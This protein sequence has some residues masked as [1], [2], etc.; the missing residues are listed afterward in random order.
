MFFRLTFLLSVFLLSTQIGNAQLISTLPNCDNTSCFQRPSN[1][2]VAGDGSFVVVLDT[3]FTDSNP[4]VYLRKL[5]FS[6]A[7]FADEKRI[8]L[9]IGGSGNPNFQIS[10]S[11]DNKKLLV[12]RGSSDLAPPAIRVVDIESGLETPINTVSSVNLFPPSFADLAGQ[13]I[14]LSGTAQQNPELLTI[15]SGNGQVIKKTKI[16][17]IADTISPDPQFNKFV[18]T[19]V[20][21]LTKSVSIVDP[22]LN[23]LNTISIDPNLD[24]GGFQQVIRFSNDGQ[25]A[26][27][28]SLGGNHSFH[29]LDLSLNK[30]TT[31]FLDPKLGGP[32]LS[33]I[34]SDGMTIVSAGDILSDPSGFKLYKTTLLGDGTGSAVSSKSFNDGSIV[35]DLV[36]TPDQS[37]ILVLVVKTSTGTKFLKTIDFNN[38]D[39]V[40]EVEL[41]SDISEADI[42]LDPN[43]RYA[44]VPNLF[45]FPS[46]SLISGL[47]LGPIL[48]NIS[49]TKVPLNQSVPFT[50][51]SFI[52]PSRFSNNVKVCF[53]DSVTCASDVSLSTDGTISGTT[54]A[55]SKSGLYDILLIAQSLS[56]V[57]DVISKYSGVI[58]GDVTTTNDFIEPSI[59][60]ISPRANK[61]F[62]ART[63]RVFGTVDGTGSS[64]KEVLVNGNKAEL[65]PDSNK[66]SVFSFSANVDFT[67]DGSSEITVSA[68]DASGNK[69]TSSVPVVI[70]TV[71]PTVQISAESSAL[72]F[73]ITGNADGTGSEVFNIVVNSMPVQFTR[74]ESVT[75]STSVVSAPIIVAVTDRAGNKSVL[76]ISNPLSSNI[77]APIITVLSPQQGSVLQGVENVDI[78]FQVTDSDGISS[79]LVD[80]EE[81]PISPNNTYQQTVALDPGKNIITITAIDSNGNESDLELSLTL[82]SDFDT[83]TNENLPNSKEII[84]LPEDVESLGDGLIMEFNDLK[85]EDPNFDITS[86][87]SVEILN[88]PFIPDGEDASVE[89]PQTNGLDAMSDEQE[90]PQGFSFASDITFRQ[91]DLT[92]LTEENLSNQNTVVLTDSSGRSFLV[93]LGFFDGVTPLESRKARLKSKSF[94]FQTTEGD[95][96]KLI[97]TITIPSDASEGDATVS[98]INGDNS[99]ATIDLKILRSKDVTVKGQDIGKPQINAPVTAEIKSSGRKLILKIPGDNFITKIASIDGQI[100]K[101]IGKAKFFTNVTFAPDT[102]IT[103]KKLSVKKKSIVLTAKIEGS[104]TSG[105]KLFNVI[106]PKGSD[107]GAITIPDPIEDGEIE[108]T[109]NTEDLILNQ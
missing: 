86:V 14:F 56:P 46:V 77:S 97:T 81:L 89:I 76:N 72:G 64:V 69:S 91:A 26:V 22:N 105:L 60:I 45:E 29:L 38:F 51:S 108:A 65:T 23:T 100:E 47:N 66:P 32:V 55:I 2:A 42:S 11:S 96:L 94:K 98:V 75:F 67:S 101:L 90:V 93:G 87:G 35:F 52:D 84:E 63:I 28:S 99:L 107:I 27:I 83:Q 17:A 20:V 68:E 82:L 40:S 73:M 88:P 31:T 50:A 5:K 70:D 44:L 15:S 24:T 16:P 21:P 78:S 41:S 13:T 85:E 109:E 106:T 8:P 1:I 33:T 25:K 104:L 34:S 71:L 39:N 79:V 9:S 6:S 53:G 80:G 7:G 61:A 49:I 19:H 37:K 57:S 3:S 92:T 103:I 74:S 4:Q 18:L 36:I 12:Y 10:L 58:F 95:L 102:G 62:N 59:N 30:I 48:K 43:G 54:P